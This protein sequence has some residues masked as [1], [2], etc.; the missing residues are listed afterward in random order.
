MSN[1]GYCRQS[2]D[3]QQSLDMQVDLV[4][5]LARRHG[6][7]LDMVR[8]ETESACLFAYNKRPE[9]AKLMNEF[10]SGD[11]LFVWRIDRI[12]RNPFRLPQAM[13]WLMNR[14]V[15]ICSHMEGV[16]DLSTLHGRMM[17]YGQ[18][19]V[20]DMFKTYLSEATMSGLSW[21]RSKGFATGMYK[22]GRKRIPIKNAMRGT[23][24]LKMDVWDTKELADV[25]EIYERVTAGETLADISESFYYT[26]RLT[27]MGRMWAPKR[28]STHTNSRY[29]L[30]N[31]DRV[32]LAYNWYRKVVDAGLQPEQLD[33]NSDEIEAIA[34]TID[35]ARLIAK[36]R[37]RDSVA[38]L[39]DGPVNE[40][41]YQ[42]A[43]S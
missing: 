37:I 43:N 10:Q 25:R 9:F 17:I 28:K 39:M 41:I 19:M 29:A 1:F 12:E 26:K 21:R 38:T 34:P 30:C 8:C 6:K 27:C 4:N 3:K 40:P 18:V 42:S 11:W 33:P 24:C 31:E 32:R 35:A 23:K 22:I 2:T 13:E 15:V 20:C 7:Q 36:E 5:D 14:G 16:I